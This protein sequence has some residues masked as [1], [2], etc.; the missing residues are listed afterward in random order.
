MIPDGISRQP[1]S[2]NLTT[3]SDS[4][5]LLPKENMEEMYQQTRKRLQ[6]K[7]AGFKSRQ[8]CV[9]PE[10]STEQGSRWGWAYNPVSSAMLSQL[11]QRWLRAPRTASSQ[12]SHVEDFKQLGSW[13]RR[14]MCALPRKDLINPGWLQKKSHELIWTAIHTDGDVKH[15]PRCR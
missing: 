9:P 13:W 7:N 14:G 12:Q 3:Q 8:G 11:S 15:S 2:S 1:K 4:K 10:P 5:A 6:N